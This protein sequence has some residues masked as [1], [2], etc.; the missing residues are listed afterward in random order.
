[1]GAVPVSSP[2]ASKLSL[3]DI[4]VKGKKVL[5]RVDFNV[6]IDSKGNI[7][8]DSRI[9]ASLPSIQYVIDQGGSLILMSHLGRPKNGFSK[10]FSLSPC[11][12]RLS[13]LLQREV[14]MAPDCIG[15]KVL[16]LANDLKPKQILMLENLRFHEGE[17]HPE[18]DK[19]FVEQLAKLGDIYVNDAFGSA[20]RAHA[21]TCE[22][23]KFFPKKAVCG[24]LLEKEINFL[25]SILQNPKRPFLAI[26]GGSKISTKCGVIEALMRK[27]DILLIGGGMAYTFLKAKGIAIGESIVE[28]DFIPKAK[29]LLEKQGK[30][31]FAKLILPVDIVVTDLIK[32]DAL[33]HVVLVDS[34]IPQDRQGVDIGPLT[35]ELF[36]K[37]LKKAQ[38]VL[39]NGPVGVFEI[40]EFA[41]GTYRIAHILADLKATTIIGGGDSL[42]AIQQTGVADKMTH[43]ST[44]GGATLEYIEFGRLPGIDALSKNN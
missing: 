38:T 3:S 40:E 39:W 42:A 32:K 8:D 36:A 44:G 14:I 30:D 11:A 12:K 15:D 23:A 4:D 1:M 41:K 29:E 24:F 31:G 7:T 27:A 13:E 20:H 33:Y 25:G 9:K 22:I 18:K 35:I 19:T 37:E 21:S 10:E 28:N 5:M 34:G 16:S 17:E 2:Q 26:I 6:P 43:L